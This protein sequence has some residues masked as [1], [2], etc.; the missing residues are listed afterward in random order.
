LNDLFETVLLDAPIARHSVSVSNQPELFQLALA[1]DQSPRHAVVF[2]TSHLARIF[3]F[4]HGQTIAV[5]TV[6]G[7]HVHRS[8]GGGWAQSRFQRH[9]DALQAEHARELVQA[10][11]QIVR[12]EDVDRIVLAGDEVNVPLIKSELPDELSTKV[13]DVL[14]LEAHSPEHDIK[15]AAADAVRRHDAAVDRAAVIAA[16]DEARA[17]GLAVA[18]LTDTMAALENGQVREL[19]L[20]N[21]DRFGGGSHDVSANELVRLA[22]RTSADLRF[23]EDVTLLA[24][25]NGIAAALRFRVKG[26]QTETQS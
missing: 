16:L 24:G 20:S 11:A 5:E 18:G 3:V 4:G 2:A 14:R 1:L 23:I 21:T 26:P 19:Y 13:I 22:K 17:R 15:E 7:R 10:L 12:D 6:Q 9:V 25:V 8:S